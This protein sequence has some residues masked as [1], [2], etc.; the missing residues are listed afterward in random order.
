MR[1]ASAFQQECYAFKET[2]ILVDYIRN[3][4]RTYNTG[5]FPLAVYFHTGKSAIDNLKDTFHIGIWSDELAYA[6]VHWAKSN[7]LAKGFKSYTNTFAIN[8]VSL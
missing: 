7:C 5:F 6:W 8:E 2:D 3:E 4:V 1:N